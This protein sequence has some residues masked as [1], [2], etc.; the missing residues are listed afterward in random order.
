MA[1]KSRYVD[2][3]RQNRGVVYG[4][5]V[6]TSVDEGQVSDWGPHESHNI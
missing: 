3:G 1:T 4:Q 2:E 5:H 6:D